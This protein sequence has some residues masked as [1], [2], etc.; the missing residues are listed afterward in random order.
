MGSTIT[1]TLAYTSMKNRGVVPVRKSSTDFEE[2][3]FSG[4]VQMQPVLL[5]GHRWPILTLCQCWQSLANGARWR[6]ASR[7]PYELYTHAYFWCLI[8]GVNLGRFLGRLKHL[9]R[10]LAP[11]ERLIAP[12]EV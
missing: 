6:S 3:S 12:H 7:E 9:A 4:A 2:P 11:E 8:L 1:N 5:K 10:T